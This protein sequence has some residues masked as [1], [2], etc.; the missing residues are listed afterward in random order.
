[1]AENRLGQKFGDPCVARAQHALL[2]GMAGEHDDRHVGIGVGA[3]LA[4]HLRQFQAVEDRHEPVGEHDIRH[5]VGEGLEA[6]RAVFGFIH[7]AR[8]E[9]VQ[10]RAQDAPHMC[11]VVDDEKTQPIEIDADH[12]ASRGGRRSTRSRALQGKVWPLTVG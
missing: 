11:V 3:G 10:Q 9:S 7:F 12:T 4:D 8:T 5:V 2:L 1:L 6:G